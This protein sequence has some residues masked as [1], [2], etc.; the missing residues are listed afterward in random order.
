MAIESNL[1]AELAFRSIIHVSTDGRKSVDLHESSRSSI[2]DLVRRK[3]NILASLFG[4]DVND[5]QLFA[6][7]WFEK[8]NYFNF[9]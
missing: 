2:G 7:A 5:A 9:S 6:F 1:V 3:A 8:G 4:L